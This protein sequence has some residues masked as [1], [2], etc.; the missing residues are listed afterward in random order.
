MGIRDLA[1]SRGATI[2]YFHRSKLH[3]KPGFNI[4]DMSAPD[5]ID[6][7][8]NLADQIEARG[9]EGNIDIFM[10]G[11]LPTIWRGHCRMAAID[12][13]ISRGKWDDDA[14]LVPALVK[15]TD[16]G[17]LEMIAEQ[18][19]NGGSKA[20]SQRENSANLLRIMGMVGQSVDRTAK[21]VGKSISW[22]SQQLAFNEA[23]TPEV[24]QAIEAGK[25]S[26]TQAAAILRKEGSKKGAETINRVVATAT[27]KGKKKATKWD[28]EANVEAKVRQSEINPTVGSTAH[29]QST[30]MFDTVASADIAPLTNDVKAPAPLDIDDV[31]RKLKGH[32]APETV[33]TAAIVLARDFLERVAFSFDD[34]AICK[35]A[36][37]IVEELNHALGKPTQMAAE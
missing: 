19:R 24:H 35:E 33:K 23:A 37:R 4:R 20:L 29:R 2:H 36:E 26:P 16:V 32:V 25:I 18:S 6:H 8:E 22:V 3:I 30:A 34:P 27:A 1:V 5:N 15:P 17:F 13:L 9:F 11:D 28:V 10:D 12:L 31:F 7:V 21:L 14:N